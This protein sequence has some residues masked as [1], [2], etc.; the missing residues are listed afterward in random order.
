MKTKNIYQKNNRENRQEV[1]NVQRMT[2]L[3]IAE[4]TGKPH[5]DV[6]RAIRN[7]ET[8]WERVNGRKFALVEYKDAKV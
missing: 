7:M 3:E 1:V 2:S 5:K 6:M 8:A 4:A